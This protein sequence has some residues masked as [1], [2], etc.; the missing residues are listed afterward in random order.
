MNVKT[1]ADVCIKKNV[2]RPKGTNVFIYQRTSLP[3]G[4]N[5]IKVRQKKRGY[6]QNWK[7]SLF[8]IKS[9]GVSLV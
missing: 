2:Q 5:P 6:P 3:K 1:A 4:R 7:S 8:F 9:E